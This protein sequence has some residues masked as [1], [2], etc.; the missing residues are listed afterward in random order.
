MQVLGSN[1]CPLRVA[2]V[3]GGP[4][5]FFAAAALLR[6]AFRVQV[7]LFD[8]MPVPY[9]LVRYGVAPDHQDLK[10]AAAAFARTAE[11]A[12]VTFHG[13]VH[14]GRDLGLEALHRCFDVVMLATGAEG[15][16]PLGIPGA[17]LPGVYSANAFVG[18]YNAHP[19]FAA[20]TPDL[21]C[22]TAVLIGNGNVA[23]DVARILL[24]QPHRLASTDI[25][26]PA[27]ERLRQS[28][29]REVVIL[30]RRGPAQASFTHAEVKELMSLDGVDAAV[31]AED[32]VFDEP[33]RE[34]GWNHP[35]PRHRMMMEDLL[36]LAAAQRLPGPRRLVFRFFRS[37]IEIHGDGR[38][39]ELVVGLNR[40][41]GPAFGRRTV[42]TGETE[43]IPCGVVVACVGFR[44]EPLP[45]VPADETT[46]AVRHLA[47]RVRVGEPPWLYATGWCKTGPRGLIGSSKKE[48]TETVATLLEDLPRIVPAPERDAGSL[49]RRLRKAGRRVFSFSDWQKLDQIELERGRATGKLREKIPSISEMQ[50]LAEQCGSQQ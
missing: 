41:E 35:D 33:D 37:P 50:R 2:I 23:V 22:E 49:L 43:R 16:R 30:G 12:E 19:E 39:Q 3:G 27:L 48:S 34:E 10:R 26:G 42:P 36:R 11:A 46:G 47:G 7:A 20:L 1:E 4:S 38:V 8:R 17:D 45:G 31:D 21:S 5:G 24:K 15:E 14:V 18:W 28:R 32:F 13:N 9:G 29:I 44:G 40:L 6:S 25:A